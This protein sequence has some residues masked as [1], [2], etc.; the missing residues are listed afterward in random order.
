MK[1]IKERA[2]IEKQEKDDKELT[3]KPQINKVSQ[4]IAADRYKDMPV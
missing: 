4:I 1:K 3:Y 2:K